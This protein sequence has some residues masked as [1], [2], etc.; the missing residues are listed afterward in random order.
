MGA[1]TKQLTDVHDVSKL[2]DMQKVAPTTRIVAEVPQEFVCEI[3][4]F[5][6]ARKLPSRSAAIRRLIERGL[7]AEKKGKGK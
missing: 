2:H 7:E 1:G 5:W 4:D 6:H 3:D